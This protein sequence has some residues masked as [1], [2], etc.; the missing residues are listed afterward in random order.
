KSLMRLALAIHGR[1]AASQ[2]GEVSIEMP[3]QAWQ[4]CVDLIRQ[5]RRAKLRSWHLAAKAVADELIYEIPSVLHELTAM[6]DRLKSQ[7]SELRISSVTDVYQDLVAL[8][9]EFEE[10]EYSSDICS[11]CVTTEPIILQGVYLGPFEIQLKI[12]RASA[13]T[14]GSYS[15]VAKDPH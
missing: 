6:Q 3:L 4:G 9:E 11:L 12:R 1:L 14:E 15:V 5:I 13:N 10:L 2:A 8:D 7:T